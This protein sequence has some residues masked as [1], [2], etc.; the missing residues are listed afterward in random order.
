MIGTEER[1][2]MRLV[3]QGIAE[4]RLRRERQERARQQTEMVATVTQ[5]ACERRVRVRDAGR[6]SALP[7]DMDAVELDREELIGGNG[8]INESL[9]ARLETPVPEL[10]EQAL[11]WPTSQ[12]VWR[13]RDARR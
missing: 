9:G 11:P 6:R 7:G 1:E 12:R 2:V 10:E 4:I 13:R 5:R 8:G 3:R